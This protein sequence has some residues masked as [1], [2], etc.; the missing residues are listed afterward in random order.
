MLA[1]PPL[2]VQ[3]ALIPSSSSSGGGLPPGPG[4]QADHAAV[5][6]RVHARPH[7]DRTATSTSCCW[8]LARSVVISG[9]VVVASRLVP[10]GRPWT[11]Q[12]HPPD[13]FHPSEC[14][15]PPSRSVTRTCT[16]GCPSSAW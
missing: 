6:V 3:Y 13:R 11:V 9:G 1:R 10:G 15:A 14:R 2:F 7:P 12:R 5:L 8:P 16:T 4:F